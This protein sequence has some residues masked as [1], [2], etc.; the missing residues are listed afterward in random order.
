MG[1]GVGEQCLSDLLQ[2]GEALF[3]PSGLIHFISL[4]LEPLRRA[5]EGQ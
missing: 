2:S 3:L 4:S 5:V 1:V